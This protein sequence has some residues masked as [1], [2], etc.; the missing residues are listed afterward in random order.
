M[1]NYVQQEINLSPISDYFQREDKV[2]SFPRLYIV[3]DPVRGL[4]RT[5]A[6]QPPSGLSPLDNGD[7]L[8]QNVLGFEILDGL[9][10]KPIKIHSFYERLVPLQFIL[11]KGEESLLFEGESC[12]PGS[13]EPQSFSGEDRPLIVT[14][15]Q[16]L[17]EVYRVVLKVE[18]G[19]LPERDPCSSYQRF[20]AWLDLDTSPTLIIERHKRKHIDDKERT[21]LL[22]HLKIR[23]TLED[24]MR[25]RMQMWISNKSSNCVLPP[26]LNSPLIGHA[27][28]LGER[29][30]DIGRR[31]LFS[32]DRRQISE[33]ELL[34]EM[35]KAFELF[36]NSNLRLP[37]P[38]GATAG[39][40][41][42]GAYFLFAELASF[43]CDVGYPEPIWSQLFSTL[44]WTQ[45]LYTTV[46]PLGE[47]QVKEHADQSSYSICNFK[48]PLVSGEVDK[49]RATV[50]GLDYSGLCRC[51]ATQCVEA[52]PG[53]LNPSDAPSP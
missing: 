43:L 32:S 14:A 13:S 21:R 48:G 8:P 49:L 40:P 34:Q 50:K 11:D 51:A 36:A 42:S 53:I 45:K 35:S 9:P 44:V 33:E 4:L 15:S 31:S 6:T 2:F 17:D 39:Q 7:T 37:L 52:M 25:E 26:E 16:Y 29:I 12:V 19:K 41:S 38:S 10:R 18:E 46:Y 27:K 30:L 5:R 1:S 20:F 3:F 23:S 22:N 24:R 47:L 28:L